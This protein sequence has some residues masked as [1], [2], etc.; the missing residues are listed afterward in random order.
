MARTDG[1]LIQAGLLHDTLEGYVD[2]SLA[3]VQERYKFT[4]PKNILALVEAVTEPP[5]GPEWH[6]WFERK[7]TVLRK[8]DAGPPAAAAL[9]CATKISTVAAGNKTLYTGCDLSE[10]SKGSLEDNLIMLRAY[11]D[12][13]V[14]KG[15]P[16]LLLDEFD[17]EMEMFSQGGPKK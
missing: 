3:D 17:R 2:K 8:I 13:F 6:N 15:V 9:C 1:E 5:K 16:Q 7:H 14:A 12:I 4:V 11:R 10:W